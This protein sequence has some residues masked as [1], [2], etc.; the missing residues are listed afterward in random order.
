MLTKKS[1]KRI[2]ILILIFTIGFS[3]YALASYY[4]SVGSPNPTISLKHYS[5]NSPIQESINQSIT[6]WN[7]SNSGV[8]IKRSDSSSNN[9]IIAGSFTDTWYG[10]ATQWKRTWVSSYKFR[11]DINTRTISR[12]ATNYGNFLQSVTVHEFGHIFW[13]ADNPPGTDPS[14]MRYSRDRNRMI[15]PQSLDITN[16]RNKYE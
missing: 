1:F 16:V 12:D 4:I 14:I 11:I 2:L 9:E 3:S 7:W 10:M 5:Y 15:T 6:E 8:Y 13:L